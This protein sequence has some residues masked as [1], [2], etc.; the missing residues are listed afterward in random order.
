MQQLSEYVTWGD[1][2]VMLNISIQVCKMF[3]D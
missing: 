1:K 3:V 2:L